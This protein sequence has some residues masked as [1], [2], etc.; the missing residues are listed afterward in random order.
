MVQDAA[1]VAQHLCGSE[2]AIAQAG[3]FVMIAELLA[4]VGPQV[5]GDLVS[6]FGTDQL[7]EDL[8]GVSIPALREERAPFN[9]GSSG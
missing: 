4:V 2:A 5:L 9:E 3:A 7:V 8:H 6:S 1:A